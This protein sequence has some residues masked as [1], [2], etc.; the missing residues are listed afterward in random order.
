MYLK[1]YYMLGVMETGE[2]LGFPGLK[3]NSTSRCLYLKEVRQ[4]TIEGK[5]QLLHLAFVAHAQP[6][7]PAYTLLC[8]HHTIH[9]R[10]NTHAYLQREKK[11]SKLEATET[12]LPFITRKEI[13]LILSDTD[14]S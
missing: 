2:F 5:T 7:T 14:N 12:I 1:L 11:K 3:P 4:R 9:H 10:H 8:T 6:H 13:K